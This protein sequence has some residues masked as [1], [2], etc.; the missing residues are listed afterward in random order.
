[1]RPGS[2]TATPQSINFRILRLFCSVLFQT[3]KWWK[4][5]MVFHLIEIWW[6]KYFFLISFK[7]E[8]PSNILS[9]CY[10]GLAGIDHILLSLNLWCTQ[11]DSFQTFLL[12][13]ITLPADLDMKD[14]KV[15]KLESFW[16]HDQIIN[17]ALCKVIGIINKFHKWVLAVV[18]KFLIFILE[19]NWNKM[20]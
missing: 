9:Y 14:R 15:W 10:L 5:W 13:T 2:N 20:G 7:S 11:C 16:I 12:L 4:N 18:L 6:Q 17:L 8:M 19:K 1:M 3:A